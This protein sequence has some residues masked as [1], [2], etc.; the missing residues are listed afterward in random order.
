MTCTTYLSNLEIGK[1]TLTIKDILVPTINLDSINGISTLLKKND[2]A[3]LS[4]YDSPVR[5]IHGLMT[6]RKTSSYG[7]LLLEM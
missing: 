7:S 4:N 2:F 3:R 1:S 6:S 5:E